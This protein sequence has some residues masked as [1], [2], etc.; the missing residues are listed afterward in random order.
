MKRLQDYRLQFRMQMQIHFIYQHNS[1]RFMTTLHSVFLAI[2]NITTY[3]QVR[4]NIY[5]SLVTITQISRINF[6][7]I[8]KMEI[9]SFLQWT[10]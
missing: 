6:S 10:Y 2:Q 3:R 8:D 1:L 5:K 4:H 9:D 7:A